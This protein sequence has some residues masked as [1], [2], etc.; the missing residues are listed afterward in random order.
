M[1]NYTIVISEE[2]RA[3]LEAALEKVHG[4]KKPQW[5]FEPED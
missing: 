3:I 4:N 2:Q 1:T 5:D